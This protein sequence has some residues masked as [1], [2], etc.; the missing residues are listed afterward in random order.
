LGKVNF[1]NNLIS[2]I[3]NYITNEKIQFDKDPYLF[4]FNDKI[5]DL[6]QNKFIKPSYEQYISKTCGYNYN[7]FIKKED[8]EHLDYQLNLIFPQ[9]EVRE[10]YLTALSTALFGQQIENIFI[11]TGKGGNGKSV[12]NGLMLKTMG[13]YA[14]KLPSNVLLNDIPTGAQP[15]IAGLDGKRFVLAQEP[16]KDKRICCSTLKELTGDKTIN[17]RGLYSSN[18]NIF[19]NLSLFLECND[20][21]KLD[22]VND[23]TNRRIRTINFI[24]KFVENKERYEELKDKPNVYLGDMYYKSEAFQDKFKHV[25]IQK[26]LFKYWPIFQKN[27]YKLNEPKTIRENTNNYMALSDDIFDWFKNIYEKGDIKTDIISINDIFEQFK[28]SDFFNNMSKVNKRTYNKSYFNEKI[29]NN[30]FLQDYIKKRDTR[31]NGQKLKSDMIIGW[32]LIE[33]EEEN[34]YINKN[35][36]KNNINNVLDF[37]NE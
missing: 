26:L 7:E 28:N 11:C 27:N 25:F 20:L 22:E 29:L 32:K 18:C 5:Y 24:S 2:E 3:R 17:A 30:M 36:H 31:F 21:P 16:N 10:Y 19:L 14:Y 4:C 37:I 1:K 35:N 9:E 13:N 12:I 8:I 34:N 33:N 6:K 15:H 23:A